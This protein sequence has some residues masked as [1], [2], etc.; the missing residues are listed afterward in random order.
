MRADVDENGLDKFQQISKQVSIHQK[1][2]SPEEKKKSRQK[3]KETRIQKYGRYVDGEKISSTIK[4]KSTEEKE[5]IRK[6][7]FATKVQ[8]GNAKIYQFFDSDGKFQ[9]EN[10]CG[11]EVF[12]KMN[13]LPRAFMR[14]SILKWSIDSKRQINVK[15]NLHHLKYSGWFMKEKE[16]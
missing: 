13:D 12:L 14:L 8:N 6:L 9:F 1:N 3:Q 15:K 2:K 7:E 4:N 5:R 16:F 11:I 10:D